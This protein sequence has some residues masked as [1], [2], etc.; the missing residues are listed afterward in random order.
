MEIWKKTNFLSLF[1]ANWK[2]LYFLDKV[3]QLNLPCLDY[4]CSKM[5]TIPLASGLHT[6][7]PLQEL[8]WPSNSRNPHITAHSFNSIFLNTII[9]TQ[10]AVSTNVSGLTNDKVTS[11]MTW[12]RYGLWSTPRITQW[13]SYKCIAQLTSVNSL[14]SGWLPFKQIVISYKPKYHQKVG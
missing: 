6:S 10:F 14:Y 13:R 1:P 9:S 2:L 3:L 4:I 7:A 5:W 11:T 8:H 12:L